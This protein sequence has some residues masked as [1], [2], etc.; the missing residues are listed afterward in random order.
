MS[1]EDVDL[2]P[3]GILSD[4]NLS[5]HIP[6]PLWLPTL[7]RHWGLVPVRSC[8]NIPI[9]VD[10]YN[11]FHMFL[12]MSTQQPLF[13]TKMP[14]HVKTLPTPLPAGIQYACDVKEQ[15][16]W[17]RS[18]MVWI[19][20]RQQSPRH[21]MF[22]N[23]KD[24][25]VRPKEKQTSNDRILHPRIGSPTKVDAQSSNGHH[26]FVSSDC[27][28]MI[29]LIMNLVSS[30]CIDNIEMSKNFFLMLSYWHMDI[31]CAHH[32]LTTGFVLLNVQYS[33]AILLLIRK[34]NPP[35]TCLKARILLKKSCWMMMQ[36]LG[37]M[38]FVAVLD[39]LEGRGCLFCSKFYLYGS[40]LCKGNTRGDKP[41]RFS[42]SDDV[43]WGCVLRCALCH[44]TGA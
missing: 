3:T 16:P 35:A 37:Q 27:C 38:L 21:S 44:L 1:G 32:Q 5:I 19:Y 34:E 40:Y 25:E 43:R 11:V 36:W 4:Q 22:L 9:K 6:Y 20:W 23:N 42:K 8:K 33:G 13:P 12:H 10:L 15:T 17:Q 24:D 26:C 28:R 7:R 30:S 39:K 31:H 41:V 14:I 18:E 2:N 29:L